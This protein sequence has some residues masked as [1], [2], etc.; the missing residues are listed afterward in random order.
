MG[1]FA[2]LLVDT[3]AEKPADYLFGYLGATSIKVSKGELLIASQ[4][5]VQASDELIE[6]YHFYLASNK[7]VTLHAE[8]DGTTAAVL[9]D[10]QFMLLEAITCTSSLNTRFE[11][12]SS[13]KCSWGSTLKVG[14]SVSL[15]M[16]WLDAPVTATVHYIG[17]ISGH[18]GTMFGVEIR[19]RIFNQTGIPGSTW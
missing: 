9:T 12:F 6:L 3:I 7:T 15:D 11:V 4:E 10:H 16:S 18:S 5:L 1:K 8:V 2:I 19:V 17:E 14:D 13:G